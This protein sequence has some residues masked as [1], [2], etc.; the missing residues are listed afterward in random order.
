[1]TVRCDKCGAPAVD[2]KRFCGACITADRKANE[3]RLNPPD[4]LACPSCAHR[5]LPASVPGSPCYSCGVIAPFDVS[6]FAPRSRHQLGLFNA[7][8]R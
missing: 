4:E 3:P 6:I 8:E 2:G 5:D 7:E 1:M